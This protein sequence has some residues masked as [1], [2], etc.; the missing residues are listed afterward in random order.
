MAATLPAGVDH[1]SIAVLPCRPSVNTGA[2]GSVSEQERMDGL[3][4]RIATLERRVLELERPRVS[5]PAARPRHVSSPSRV[6]A[7]A[8]AAAYR[9][10]AAPRQRPAPAA[11]RR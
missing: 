10:P 1:R 7:T 2:E 9:P 5:T 4:G 11:P 8:A 6:V 3:E